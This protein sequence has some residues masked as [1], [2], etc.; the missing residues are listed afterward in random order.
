MN[1]DYRRCDRCGREWEDCPGHYLRRCDRCRLFIRSMTPGMSLLR[2]V[3]HDL[4]CIMGYPKGLRGLRPGS[5][6]VVEKYRE[7]GER[8]DHP[9]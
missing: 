6:E 5:F 1:F 4:C 2:S 7:K 9:G 3:W 8:N